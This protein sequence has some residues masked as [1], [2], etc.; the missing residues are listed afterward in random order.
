MLDDYDR[1]MITGAAGF[2]GSHLCEEVLDLGK[3]VVVIDD[4]STGKEENLPAEADFIKMDIADLGSLQDAMMGIDLVFHLAAQPSTRNS[5][6]NPY[7]D[8]HS[9]TLGTY[10]V[11]AAARG[12]GVRRLIYTSSSAVYGEPE[13]LPL[14]E[15]DLPI[16]MT[17][18]GA[19]KLCGEHYCTAFA[20]VYQLPCVCFRPFNVYGPRENLDTSLDEVIHYTA[21]ILEGRPVTVYGDGS[22][23]RDFVNVKDV[24]RAHI[25]AADNDKSIGKVFNVGTG[26]ETSI[27]EL[28]KEIEKVT[29]R[30]AQLQH[31]AWPEG[32]IRREFAD[33]SLAHKTINYSPQTELDHGINQILID[34]EESSS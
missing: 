18:Y 27:N 26:R 22:Q 24:V 3:Q 20:G 14:T 23:T 31:E 32:D 15:A 8:F 9:N 1:V 19:S 2:I 16:P 4:L 33:I 28:V 21:A 13:R 10:N 25:L 11:L 34:L 17:P 30:Q 7:L 5:I 12:A 29:G 6:E